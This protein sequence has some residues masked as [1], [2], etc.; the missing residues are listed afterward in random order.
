[1]WYIIDMKKITLAIVLMISTLSA[2]AK[3]IG[4]YYGDIKLPTIIYQDEVEY[5]GQ[6]VSGKFNAY[7]SGKFEI[8]VDTESANS[9]LIHEMTHYYIFV[10]KLDLQGYNEEYLCSMVE[11]LDDFFEQP[12]T[13]VV[14]YRQRGYRFERSKMKEYI[15]IF[16]KVFCG[17]DS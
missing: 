14:N 7:K 3:P 11:A 8:L 9:V 2:Y 16:N 12:N 10:N 5:N 15:K 17:I 1:M 4:Y 6:L 13:T